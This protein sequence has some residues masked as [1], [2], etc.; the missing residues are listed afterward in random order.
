MSSSPNWALGYIPAPSEW[1]GVFAGKVDVGGDASTNTVIPT[2]GAAAI[3][4]ADLAGQVNG[5]NIS[6]KNITFLGPVTGGPY[7]G[8]IN[9]YSAISGTM[10]GG[11]PA[12]VNI[13]TP[14]D[15]GNFGTGSFGGI[16]VNLNCGGAASIGNRVGASINLNYAGGPGNRSAGSGGSPIGLS[17]NSFMSGNVGGASGSYYGS[18]WGAVIWAQANAGTTWLGSNIGLEVDTA[19][20]AGT[21]VAYNLGLVLANFNLLTDPATH[22]GDCAIAIAGSSSNGY[23]S[24][25]S[26]GHQN[27]G[28]PFPANGV[29][30]DTANPPYSGS[31]W[32][33]TCAYGLRLTGCTFTTAAW[34]STGALIDGSG[35]ATFASV[36]GGANLFEITA[37]NGQGVF[38]NNGAAGNANLLVDV[39]AANLVQLS[40]NGGTNTGIRIG[41]GGTGYIAMASPMT[42]TVWGSYASNA[43]AV[44]AGVPSGGLFTNTTIGA[45]C[46]RT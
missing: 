7:Y 24:G 43:A 16:Y 22:Q 46:A 28:W 32:A 8:L 36:K 14:S 6:P 13:Q 40:P 39:S 15:T 12:I 4:L 25:I 38:I 1:S 31:P 11:S 3:T 5:G 9:Y 42:V 20:K 27:G 33:Y 18:N 17:V 44:S 10:T 41:A 19:V 30:I 45:L 29:L 37:A 21:S 35:N 34:A 23:F 2:G 26:F